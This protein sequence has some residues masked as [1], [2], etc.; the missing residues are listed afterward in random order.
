MLVLMTWLW[1]TGASALVLLVLMGL[2]RVLIGPASGR[3]RQRPA[4]LVGL[5]SA[6]HS[7][8]REPQAA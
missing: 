7:D 1:T 8:V 4:V 2:Q 3:R 6:V 5:T